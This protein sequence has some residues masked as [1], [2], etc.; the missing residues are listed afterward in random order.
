VNVNEIDV[1][2]LKTRMDANDDIYLIDIRSEAEVAQGVLP[3]SE[4]LPMHM[5]PLRMADFPKDRDIILY[6]RSGARSHHACSYLMQQ[7]IM[8]C[9]NMQG[10][11]IAWARSGFEVLPMDQ[12][13]K[14]IGA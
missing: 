5:I 6:C 13:A 2:T 12:A 14:Q 8:N 3:D 10:G 11:I 1:A 9:L 7:G 4:F